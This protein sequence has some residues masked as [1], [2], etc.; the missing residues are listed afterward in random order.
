MFFMV[1]QRGPVRQIWI[2]KPNQEEED[3]FYKR[4]NKT[5]TNPYIIESL[6]K[7]HSFSGFYEWDGESNELIRIQPEDRGFKSDLIARLI[8]PGSLKKLI[9]CTQNNRATFELQRYEEPVEGFIW[10]QGQE[11]NS[12]YF[13]GGLE[14]EDQD[15]T[16]LMPADT[17]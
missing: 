2:T 9:N 6:K 14:I 16:D 4:E 8:L 5:S 15:Y 12:K 13:I 10:R 3:A 11:E 1:L 7:Y 17:D